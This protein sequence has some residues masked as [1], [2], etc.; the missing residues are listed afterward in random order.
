MS[1][2]YGMSIKITGH[3]ENK[4]RIIFEAIREEWDF[5]DELFHN[6]PSDEDCPSFL[7][8]YGESFLCGGESEEEFTD[9]VALAVWKANEGYCRV[10]VIATYLEDLPYETHIRNDDDYY[11]LA[12]REKRE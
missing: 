10:E 9:R 7:S 8:A 6:V 3:D 12:E 5:Q 11:R 2:Y 1:R 4:A